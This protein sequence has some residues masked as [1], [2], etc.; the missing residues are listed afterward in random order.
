MLGIGAYEMQSDIT[1]FTIPYRI[2]SARW[3]LPSSFTP[4]TELGSQ[5]YGPDEAEDPGPVDS[6]PPILTRQG[7]R[8]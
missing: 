5:R 4:G 2:L 3:P 6:Q 8:A 1:S 7:V